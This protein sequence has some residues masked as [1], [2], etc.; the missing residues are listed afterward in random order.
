MS[1]YSHKRTLTTLSERLT[2]T[3]TTGWFGARFYLLWF[4]ERVMDDVRP[5]LDPTHRTGFG[6]VARRDA[7]PIC[8]ARGPHAAVSPWRTS[9]VKALAIVVMVL[10]GLSV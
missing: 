7:G 2:D 5:L 4:R 10:T 6:D 8:R 9:A 1:A 3:G